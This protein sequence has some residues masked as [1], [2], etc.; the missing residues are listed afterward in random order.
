[1]AC[2]NRPRELA[3]KWGVILVFGSMALLGAVTWSTV[4]LSLAEQTTGLPLGFPPP[5]SPKETL[6]SIAVPKGLRVELVA[7]EPDIVDPVAFTWDAQGRLYVVEMNDYPHGPPAGRV[8]LL[9]GIRGEGKIDRVTVFA[10][11]L[12][13]PDGVFPWRP[14]VLVTAAPNIWYLE[15][16]DGD[17]RADIKR[18]IFTGFHEGNPQHRV[19]GLVWGLDNWIYGCNGDSGGIIRAPDHPDRPAVEIRGRDFRFR[20]D[21]REIEPI[22]G[23]SQFGQTFDAWGR[24]FFCNNRVHIRLAPIAERYLRRA[25][26]LAFNNLLNIAE[27]GP[28]GAKVF[29]ISQVQERFNDYTHTGHFTSACSVHIYLGDLLSRDYIGCAYTC[30]PVHN[31]VHRC[32]ISPRGSMFVAQRAEENYEF[33]ASSDP[34]CR[35]VYINTGPDGALYIADFY[36][37]VVEHPQWIPPEV[38]K[39]LNLRAGEDR[40]RIYRIVPENFTSWQYPNLQHVNNE[41]LVAELAHP[42]VWRRDTAQRLLFERQDKSVVPTLTRMASSHP[43]PQVRLRALWTLDGLGALPDEIIAANLAHAEV[44]LRENALILAERRLSKSSFLQEKV[45]GLAC[46]SEPRIRFQLALTLGEMPL[47]KAYTALVPIAWRDSEDP[48]VRAAILASVA[49]E[50]LT[51]TK[52]L[53]DNAAFLE[54]ATPGRIALL[55]ELGRLIGGRQKDE[56]IAEFLTIT[57]TPKLSFANQLTLVTAVLEGRARRNPLTILS[58]ANPATQEHLER[59]RRQAAAILQQQGSVEEQIAALRFLSVWAPKE[60]KAISEQFLHAR[61]PQELQLAA[62]RA[63]STNLDETGT[64]F[65]LGR[66]A[67]LSPGVRLEALELIFRNRQTAPWILAALEKGELRVADLDARRR[68]QLRDTLTGE[69]RVRAEQLLRSLAP[70]KEI[71]QSYRDIVTLAADAKR[72]GDLFKKHCAQCHQRDG[73]GI[74]VG[75]NLDDVRGK[76]REQLLED[77]LDPNAAVAPNYA[78]Y[79]VETRNGQV[80][81]GILA[82]ETATRIVLLRAEG[83]REEILRS[84]IAEIRATSLSLMPENLEQNLTKQDLADIIAWLRQP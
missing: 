28:V 76:T 14:G 23:Q 16:A 13:F 71:V 20:P 84:D 18:V 47:T 26:D 9:Q 68:Q 52:T 53:T 66:L 54:E 64:R 1:M 65:L 6:A 39:R 74:A 79:V 78:T 75:P 61:F 25:P 48:W 50:P 45:L 51:F 30:E 2:R 44:G 35:P 81:T 69:L 73:Q 21:T 12:P 58:R 82:T 60:A 29:H 4:S 7:A 72:G 8:K 43:D 27:Y 41:Q 15:D 3:A 24:R 62:L 17:G 42:N 5:R 38:Q 31:L 83:V 10:E 33:L 80:Y 77:I 55:V 70:R 57:L 32:R 59:L 19:N 46:A 56:E 34:W 63:Y 36:R 37:A 22:S 67:E 11:G 40:G 49:K